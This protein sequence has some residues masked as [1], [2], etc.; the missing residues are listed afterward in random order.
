MATFSEDRVKEIVAK[1]LTD[2]RQDLLRQFA[3]LRGEER[4]DPIRRPRLRDVP[5]DEDERD[6]HRDTD[7]ERADARCR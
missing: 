1:S 6:D 7:D 5:L 2:S 4:L 3:A